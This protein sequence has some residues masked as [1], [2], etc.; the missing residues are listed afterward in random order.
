MNIYLKQIRLALF[1]TFT[2]WHLAEMPAS[3]AVSGRGRVP[4]ET[5]SK[6]LLVTA[7]LITI[8]HAALVTTFH[9][10]HWRLQQKRSSLFLIRN[11]SPAVTSKTWNWPPRLS[12]ELQMSYSVYVGYVFKWPEVKCDSQLHCIFLILLATKQKINIVLSNKSASTSFSAQ[13]P[14]NCTWVWL[15]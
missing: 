6:T 11:A 2:I 1:N 8:L 9:I 5:S 10:T 4:T 3:I 14:L 15:N 7:P 13:F 12:S